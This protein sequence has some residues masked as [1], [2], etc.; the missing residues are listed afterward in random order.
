MTSLPA[1]LSAALQEGIAAVAASG[2]LTAHNEAMRAVQAAF[3][4]PGAHAADLRALGVDPADEARLRAGE[5]VDVSVRARHWRLRLV[6]ADGADWLL[7]AE[8]TDAWRAGASRVELARLRAL[9]KA[10]GTIVHDFNNML[11]SVIGLG[12]MVRPFVI[13]ST[14]VQIL[15]EL[16]K[17]TQHGSQLMR[18][19]ARMLTRP[20]GDRSRAALT[21]LVDA[22]LTMANKAFLQRGVKVEWAPATPSPLLRTEVAEASQSLWHGMI[23]LCEMK[24]STLRIF[25]DADTFA[26]G[27]GRPRRWARARLVA[28]GVDPAVAAETARLF[29]GATGWLKAIG[30]GALTDGLAASLFVQRRLGGD[31]VATA[32]DGE[33]K[34]DFLLPALA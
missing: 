29:A 19:I 5:P 12:A 24:P 32:G 34:L 30:G 31:I 6:A 7:A 13:D 22:A 27:D 16:T 3:S 8:T 4:R 9:A 1:A 20:T 10:S 18:V 14:D 26:I 33:L 21:A 17:G 28:A 23:A 11:N 15:E 25:A 2:A